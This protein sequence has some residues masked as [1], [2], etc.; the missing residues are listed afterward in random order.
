M[1]GGDIDRTAIFEA[2]SKIKEDMLKLNQELFELKS[3]QKMIL[4]ENNKLKQELYK[5]SDSSTFDP[6]LVSKIV[7]ETLKQVPENK[8]ARKIYKK[9]KNIVL[10]RIKNLAARKNLTIPEIKD[11][12]VENESL[13]SRA[14]FYRYVDILK[15]K[16]MIEIMKIND[17]EVVVSI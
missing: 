17:I 14:T 16:G 3:E 10:A 8:P 9:R 6:V 12:V 13:C 15:T 5:N 4:E 1:T 7:K 2:F 11:I